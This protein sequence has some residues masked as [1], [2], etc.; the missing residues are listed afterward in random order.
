MSTSK[1]RNP[2]PSI[3]SIMT[4]KI[5]N[6][7]NDRVK[8]NKLDVY[9]GERDELN[10][11]L[12][13]MKLYFAF[14]SI[15]KNQKTLFA[16][17]YLR[18]RAQHWFKSKVRTYLDD[19][20]NI[21]DK[22]FTRFNNFK[23]AIRRIFGIFNEEQFVERIIQHLKQHEFAFDYVARFQ[24]YANIIDWDESTLQTMY[25]RGLKEQVKDEL[26]RDEKAYETLD[27][28]IEIFIDLD[29]KLYERAM[30]KKYDEEPR[31]RTETYSG[32][33]PSS[34]HGG[35][36]FGKGRRADEPADIVPMELNSTIRLNKE[37]NPKARRGN[38]KKDKTCYS[39]DK[40]SHFARDCRSRGMVPQRQINAMLR[41]ELDEWKTQNIDSN[42]SNITR[43]TTNEEYFRI[44]NLEELQQVLDEEVTSTALA[45]TKE[46]NNIIK[47]AYNKSSYLIEG[48][49]HSNEKYDYDNEEMTQD[50][51]KLA[52][53]VEKATTI[54]KDNATKIVNTLE[55]VISNDATKKDEIP[56]L[57]RSKLRRQ[58]VKVEERKVSPIC[59]N[60]W[61]DCQNEQCRIHQGLW[62][63]WLNIQRQNCNDSKKLKQFNKLITRPRKSI[64]VQINNMSLA[65][66][67]KERAPQWKAHYRSATISKEPYNK[68][69]QLIM[70]VPFARLYDLNF[71]DLR[72]W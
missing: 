2:A 36:S 56:L 5:N 69:T 60:Y 8:T 18:G 39:C 9:K 70:H 14:N 63:Q 62:R 23:A 40:S 13:Q 31:R 68:S 52:K 51:R 45:S 55:E 50:L 19:E 47:K 72:R 17:T 49:S 42:N 66:Q 15:S 1:Q 41:R 35:S 4:L 10:D 71:I 21:N 27:E 25:R 34:Y 12:I 29:D 48:K 7:S 43:T 46:I 20:K 33:L 16:F 64:Q 38:M 58:N 53:E 61:K 24:E 22:I 54:I 67:G 3:I 37:K 44:W 65:K 30:E 57:L 26:M 28:L 11:W 6:H 59:N 32:R